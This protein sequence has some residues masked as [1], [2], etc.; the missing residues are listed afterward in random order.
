MDTRE[1]SKFLK[2]TGDL[3][4]ITAGATARVNLEAIKNE[5]GYNLNTLLIKNNAG[6]E[7]SVTLDGKKVAF[8]GGSGDVLA[9][10]WEDGI[11][12][13]DIAITNEDGA[14]DTAANEIRISVGRTGAS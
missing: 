6:E 5:F 10:D 13:S 1:N 8:I 4:I 2:I 14:T 11:I 9:L 7:L 3:G 12:F